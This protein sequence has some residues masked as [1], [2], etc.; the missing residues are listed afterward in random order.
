MDEK[1]EALQTADEYLDKLK[2]G[3]NKA[4][5]LIE[6]GNESR[7]CNYIADIA[8]GIDWVVKVVILTSDI[9][10]EK[11]DYNSINEKLSE[12]VEALENEDYILLGDLFKYEILPLLDTIHKQIKVCVLN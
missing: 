1:F 6:E 7:G 10:K 12:V 5:N 4:I 2:N 9:Q 3:I 8:E 11:I